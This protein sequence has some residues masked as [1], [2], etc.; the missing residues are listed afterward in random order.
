VGTRGALA[1]V[2]TVI[3]QE[4]WFLHL[5][6]EPF[7]PGTDLGFRWVPLGWRWSPTFGM[8]GHVPFSQ[9]GLGSRT[10]PVPDEDGWVDV[11]D[12]ALIQRELRRGYLHLD[13]GVQYFTS[14]KPA[15]A[16]ELGLGLRLFHRPSIRSVGILPALDL[17]CGLYF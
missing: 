3:V 15:L 2:G 16:C 14:W 11:K 8:G 10:E 13:V 9:L 7:G 1:L 12:P 4:R 6:V 5:S 17:G